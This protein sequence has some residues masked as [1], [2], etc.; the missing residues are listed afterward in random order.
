MDSLSEN[1]QKLIFE[2][3]GVGQPSDW[4]GGESGVTI[5]IG[6]DLGYESGFR[7]DW[8]SC[9]DAATRDALAAAV[10]LKGEEAKAKAPAFKSIRIQSSDAQKIFVERSAP[11][12]IKMTEGA[13]P[14][15]DKLPADAQGALVSL[16]YNRGAAMQGDS[17]LE[18]RNIRDA[19][20][21]GDLQT[22]ADQLRAMKRLWAGKGMDGLLKRRDAEAALVESCITPAA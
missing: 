16:V 17:R 13:F 5:G 7:N 15:I 19:V 1:A 18:M 6:Y 4:P 22:I 20:A 21:R 14:G 11:K 10:G 12:Y 8:G 2:F 3:E 9:L